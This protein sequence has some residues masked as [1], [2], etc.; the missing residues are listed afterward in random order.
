MTSR[1][2]WLASYRYRDKV[3]RILVN[4]RSGR[5]SGERPYS[6]VKITALVLAILAA[7]LSRQQSIRGKK[8]KNAAKRQAENRRKTVNLLLRYVVKK[9]CRD[10]PNSLETVMTIVEW[11]DAACGIDASEPQVRRDIHAALKQSPLP[12]W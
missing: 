7:N 4:A 9:R 12:K 6:W 11:L 8:S 5:V 1:T 3:Y 2:V 10:N